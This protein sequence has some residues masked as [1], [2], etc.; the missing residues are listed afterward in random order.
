MRALICATIFC[1]GAASAAGAA[2]PSEVAVRLREPRDF[3][4]FVGDVFRREADIVVRAPYRLDPASEPKPRRL[5]YWLDLRDVALTDR[6]V[7][8]GRRYRL[9]LDYQTFYVPLSAVR[10]TA[11]GITLRFAAGERTIDAELPAFSFVMSPLREVQP[12]QPETG[13]EGYL[14]PDA[15]PRA[16]S[17]RRARIGA[18]AG[19]GVA[20]LGLAALAYHQAWW[21]FRERPKRPF[22]R[23][24]AAIRRRLKEDADPE[25]YR[26]SL[27]DLH[28]A[29]DQSA[30]RRLLADDVPGFLSV[31]PDFQPLREDISRFFANS[32]RAFFGNDPEG[33]ARTMPA[34]ALAELGAR[35]SEAER[36][37]A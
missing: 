23:A 21:P 25:S 14:K 19:A 17:T 34:G 27:L 1:A 26:Q 33:A 13:P 37:E 31:R 2:G 28:R 22:T 20:L 36:R 32:R 6:A 11:P 10:L 8:G 12:A 7:S 3:G 15:T 9:V 4:Y 29:F 18:G 5:N 16:R 24:A 30:G 35:L